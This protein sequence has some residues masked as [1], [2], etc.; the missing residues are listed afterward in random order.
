MMARKSQKRFTSRES[1]AQFGQGVWGITGCLIVI[2]FLAI[3][4]AILSGWAHITPSG[5]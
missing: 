2:G 3:V 5:R 1:L 4:I